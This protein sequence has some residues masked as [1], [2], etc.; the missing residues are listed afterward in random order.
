MAPVARSR[1]ARLI[2]RSTTRNGWTSLRVKIDGAIEFTDDDRDVKS[3]SPNGHFRLEEGSWLSGRAYDVKADSA[4]NLT[5]TYSVG[6]VHEAAGRRGAGM[7]GALAPAGDS[8]QRDRSG[9]PRR[10]NTPARRS[11]GGN[12]RDWIDPQRWIEAHL[13]GAAFFASDT[14][15]GAT[16][17][18]RKTDSRNL[19]GWR[20]SAGAH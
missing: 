12:N 15:H 11:A 8:R 9:T 2:W 6:W 14:E 3:L 17:R 16:Q 5:K 19:V 10:A 18:R 13:S 20:Q 4:G 7:A 1:V